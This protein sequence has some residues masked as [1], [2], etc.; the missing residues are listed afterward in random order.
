MLAASSGDT[1]PQKLDVPVKLSERS[2][3]LR[4]VTRGGCEGREAT[5]D[6]KFDGAGHPDRSHYGALVLT[7]PYSQHLIDE[8]LSDFLH[9]CEVK[10][11]LLESLEAPHQS[12][13]LR[14]TDEADP[15]AKKPY[16]C[17][18]TC[19]LVILVRVC[20]EDIRNGRGSG[21]IHLPPHP[22]TDDYVACPDGLIVAN[23]IY[24]PPEARRF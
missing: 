5:A 4:G 3:V 18:C 14:A 12:L 10:H 11:N 16:N 9:P 17:T 19:E 6:H 22:G 24:G 7:G 21:R 13:S 8:A 1:P 15:K 23:I 2:D 20:A